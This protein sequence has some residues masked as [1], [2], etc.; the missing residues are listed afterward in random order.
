[1]PYIY[2]CTLRALV[3]HTVKN[4]LCLFA[5]IINCSGEGW[6]LSKL[7]RV[8]SVHWAFNILER[9]HFSPQVNYFLFTLFLVLFFK[10]P[11]YWN[12]LFTANSVVYELFFRMSAMLLYMLVP[13]NSDLYAKTMIFF[14]VCMAPQL[15]V[16]LPNTGQRLYCPYTLLVSHLLETDVY[17]FF[18]H[19]QL[20]QQ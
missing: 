4:Y 18:C 1:M 9:R 20:V 17:T 14:I 2:R 11:W 6:V 3:I 19:F 5:L 8:I 16:P 12:C 15:P 10:N 7:W 13:A